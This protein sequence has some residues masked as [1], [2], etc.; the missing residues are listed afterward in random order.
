[1]AVF[2]S[3]KISVLSDSKRPL[4]FF[5]G[6]WN[7]LAIGSIIQRFLRERVDEQQ[8]ELMRARQSAT[9][10]KERETLASESLGKVRERDIRGS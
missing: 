2:K 8:I 3:I 10:K 4:E 5:R 6:T 7:R 1:M 9:N